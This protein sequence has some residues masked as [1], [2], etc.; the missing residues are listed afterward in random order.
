MSG[1]EGTLYA[2]A[3]PSTAEC[4]WSESPAFP[5]SLP[6]SV[7]RPFPADSHAEGR[8]PYKGSRPALDRRLGGKGI[9]L[10]YTVPWRP[11]GIC[12]N[13]PINSAADLKGVKWRAHSPATARVAELVGPQPVT[14][15]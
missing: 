3:V 4:G 11:Q 8:T 9:M 15:Q 12:V 13:K 7:R 14:V 5:R 10:L 2:F 1:R 6:V